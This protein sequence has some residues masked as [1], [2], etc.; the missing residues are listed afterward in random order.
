[1][2]FKI[3]DV[4]DISKML[5]ILRMMGKGEFK[6][7]AELLDETIARVHRFAKEHGMSIQ[8]ISPTGERI[9]EFTAAGILLGA[10]AGFYLGN[11]PGALLGAAVGGIAG[12]LA[13][14]VTLVMDRHG[15]NDWALIKII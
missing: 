10:A 13:S 4:R 11:I 6:I 1:M 15:A 14:H 2:N 3:D 5:G 12:R 8:I 9:I 7:A